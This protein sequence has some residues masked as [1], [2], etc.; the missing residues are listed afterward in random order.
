[1]AM[2]DDVERWQNQ[3][4]YIRL[5]DHASDC[6]TNLRFADDVLLFST[7]LVQ[8]QKMLCDFKQSTESEGLK[9]RPDKTKILS[10]H[11]TNKRKEVEVNNL[12]VEILFACESAKYIG[13]KIHSSTRNQPRSKIDSGRPGRRSTDTNES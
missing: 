6:L 11:S 13:Q 9:L 5:D 7:S 3:K 12:K 10:N 8:L 1:M 4:A 2:T